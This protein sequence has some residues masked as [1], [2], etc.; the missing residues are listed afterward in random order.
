MA[1]VYLSTC[2]GLF[3]YF[4]VTYNVGFRNH[5]MRQLLTDILMDIFRIQLL[6]DERYT[7]LLPAVHDLQRFHCEITMIG[8]ATELLCDAF[9]L[10]D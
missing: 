4:A 9:D 7:F 10:S 5:F 1:R 3:C 2:N 8:N 6:S